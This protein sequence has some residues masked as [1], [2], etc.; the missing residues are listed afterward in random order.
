MLLPIQ[1]AL[2]LVQLPCTTGGCNRLD[3]YFFSSLLVKIV[4]NQLSLH[5]YLSCWVVQK[6]KNQQ[7]FINLYNHS[8]HFRLEPYQFIFQ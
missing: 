5:E 4:M 8:Y 1:I 6:Y 7:S 2:H 3:Q